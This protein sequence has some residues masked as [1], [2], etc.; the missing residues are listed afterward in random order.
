MSSVKVSEDLIRVMRPPPPA[1]PEVRSVRTV[2]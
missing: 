1:L 2:V